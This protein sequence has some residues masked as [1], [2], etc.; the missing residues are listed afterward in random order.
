MICCGVLQNVIFLPYTIRCGV[1]QNVIFLPYMICYGVLQNVIFLPY[2]ICCGPC[3]RTFIS[4]CISSWSHIHFLF[5]LGILDQRPFS[6]LRSC[7]DKSCK[8][9]PQVFRNIFIFINIML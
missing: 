7:D 1:L 3:N 5:S 4:V 9:D 2:M 8:G 6:M